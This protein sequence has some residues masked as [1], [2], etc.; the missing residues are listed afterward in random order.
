[1]SLHRSISSTGN[2]LC[3]SAKG[4]GDGTAY[5]DISELQSLEIVNN[6]WLH[7][8]SDI[9]F[10]FIRTVFKKYLSRVQVNIFGKLVAHSFP[11][12]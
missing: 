11:S 9:V 7:M 2:L 1:M 3:I 6:V 5:L 12:L 10:T 4:S 8:F